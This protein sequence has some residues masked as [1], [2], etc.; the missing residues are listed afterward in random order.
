MNEEL[1][2][3]M[4]NNR[5]K[6]ILGLIGT[7]SILVLIAGAVMLAI[8]ITKFNDAKT[9]TS[10]FTATRSTFTAV[11]NG[12]TSPQT[13]S[14]GNTSPSSNNTTQ[15]SS[16]TVILSTNTQPAS[17][18]QTQSTIA[19]TPTTI[20]PL[21]SSIAH[22]LPPSTLKTS[23]SSF[24]TTTSQPLTQS[25]SNTIL[26]TTPNNNQPNCQRDIA[27][28]IDN[29]RMAGN[30]TDFQKQMKFISDKLISNWIVDPNSTEV[31]AFLYNTQQPK[32]IGRPFLYYNVKTLILDLQDQLQSFTYFQPDISFGISTLIDNLQNRRLNIPLVTVLFTYSR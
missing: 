8:G 29:S 7:F 25:S 5:S 12:M 10:I 11:G 18:T 26:P 15:I 23:L 6:V 27:I 21:T 16:S 1:T 9:T 19:S 14:T 17:R 30:L 13:N 24:F 20:M 2:F 3:T 28:L 4:V 31:A 32:V 22:S